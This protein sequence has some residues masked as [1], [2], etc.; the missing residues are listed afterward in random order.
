M[1]EYVTNV[2]Y[3]LRKE[4][5]VTQEE[6]AKVISVS[7]QTVVAIEKGNYVPSLLLGMKIASF[8]KKKVE[9]VFLYKYEK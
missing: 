8:F 9:E 7:R 5:G 6:F 3:E 4:K 1:K 2:V